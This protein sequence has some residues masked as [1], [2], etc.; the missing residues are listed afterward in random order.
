MAR[1][2]PYD[3]TVAGDRFPL[4][5]NL[6]GYSIF[7]I[8]GLVAWLVRVWNVRRLRRRVA[9][10]GPVF[11][12]YGALAVPRTR[13]GRYTLQLYPLDAAPGAAPQ[14]GVPLLVTGGLPINTGFAVEVKGVPRPWAPLI[15]R[16]GDTV[17]WPSARARPPG[18][19]RRPATIVPAEE[20]GVAAGR[21]A[22][23]GTR[24]ST[25]WW[26]V[27]VPE[28]VVVGVGVGVLALVAGI[29][30]SNAADARR[31]ERTG[32]EVIAEIVDHEGVDDILVL[33]YEADG[34]TVT[35]EAPVD[36][37]SDYPKGRRYP[38]W[39]DPKD[40]QRLRLLTEP[41]NDVQPIVWGGLPVAGALLLLG[42]ALVYLRRNRRVDG[43][44]WR[45]NRGPGHPRR[46]VARDGWQP[47]RRRV[48][49]PSG[50]WICVGARRR[51]H[52]RRPVTR[53]AGRACSRRSAHRR[54][55]P[56]HMHPPRRH[57]HAEVDRRH[58]RHRRLARHPRLTG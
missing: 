13:W 9:A 49:R 16:A 2:H 21:R 53:R 15:V 6:V 51:A 57:P 29:T 10:E 8:P 11:A 44:W 35:G 17:L 7:I 42:R 23:R 30:F 45:A 22:R 3:V 12:M 20:L 5:T 43:P 33:R 58:R 47:R 28:L 56:R 36:F 50:G 52:R 19:R 39:V 38:A 26:R 46:P 27:L 32:R 1:G 37:A 55:R 4:T 25:R 48:A 14:C 31:V 34:A 54:R 18:D 24:P 40:P 41:Y